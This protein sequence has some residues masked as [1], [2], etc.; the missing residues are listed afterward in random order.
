M[1]HTIQLAVNEFFFFLRVQISEDAENLQSFK[2]ER[3]DHISLD[4]KDY[5]NAF[6]KMCITYHINLSCKL[7]CL[8]DSINCDSHQIIISTD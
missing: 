7:I 3:F 1:T 2:K 6:L 8:V 4:D 5:N